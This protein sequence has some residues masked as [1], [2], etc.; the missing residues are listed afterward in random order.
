MIPD[1]TP[2]NSFSALR[3]MAA[4]SGLRT[5]RPHSSVRARATEHS[6]AADDDSPAPSA[7]H[8]SRAMLAPP[9]GNP[10]ASRDHATPAGYFAQPGTSSGGSPLDRRSASGIST[11]ALG[12][13]R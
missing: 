11:T 6:S 9:T 1:G 10:A 13:R 4:S 7:R 12:S 5:A 8:E 2:T 3:A